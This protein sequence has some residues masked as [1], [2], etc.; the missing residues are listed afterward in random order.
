MKSLLVM[1]LFAPL[2]MASPAQRS[3]EVMWET[4]P[5]A[6]KYIVEI[7]YRQGKFLKTFTTKDP[8]FKFRTPVGNYQLRARI[9]VKSGHLG[10]WSE[11]EK[12]V[13]PPEPVLF[14]PEFSEAIKAKPVNGRAAAV[15][16]KWARVGTASGYHLKVQ[17]RDGK[18]VAEKRVK[19]PA[20]KLELPPGEYTYS[21]VA[22]GAEGLESEERVSP[23][24]VLIGNA[25]VADIKM[26]PE[27]GKSGV[28]EW[29]AAPGLAY[30]VSLAR[31]AFLSDEWNPILKDQVL[32]QTGAWS[33]GADLKPG[34]YRWS[35]VAEKDGW[36]SSAPVVREFE[37]KPRE[38]RLTGLDKELDGAF[39][40]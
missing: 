33:P 7:R 23:Q 22:L 9:E 28:F 27:G 14:G 10:P 39:E 19:A 15:D 20:A 25:I 5:D 40:Q 38:T 17:D 2:A 29:E 30:R 26:M 36:T 11:W 32:N 37:I 8:L 35:L 21:I 12:L 3:V 1:V 34:R 24:K 4:E 6:V 13:V 31:S 18:I 16:L